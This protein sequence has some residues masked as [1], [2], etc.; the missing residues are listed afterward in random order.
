MEKILP[1]FLM[2]INFLMSDTDQM[3]LISELTFPSKIVNIFEGV[4]RNNSIPRL[5]GL[6]D[7]TSLSTERMN[8]TKNFL[9]QKNKKKKISSLAGRGNGKPLEPRIKN[10]IM[11]SEITE[12]KVIR[13]EILDWISNSFVGK[14]DRVRSLAAEL[15]IGAFERAEDLTT[16][17]GNEADSDEE[18]D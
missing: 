8:L 2:K 7:G 14:D 12:I 17:D 15:I 5:K 9:G 6:K 3:K 16:N 4:P 10:L 13:K 1:L 11:E 18:S